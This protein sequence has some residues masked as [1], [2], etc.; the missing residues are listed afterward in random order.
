MPASCG[1][2]T[3]TLDRVS[4]HQI[5]PFSFTIR[6]LCSEAGA[7]MSQLERLVADADTDTDTDANIHLPRTN[8]T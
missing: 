5:R 7:A 8:A 6:Y 4:Y 1:R 3:R 2:G